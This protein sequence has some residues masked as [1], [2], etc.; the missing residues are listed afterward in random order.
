MTLHHAP[1]TPWRPKKNLDAGDN[2]KVGKKKRRAAPAG[3]AGDD[4]S[5]RRVLNLRPDRKL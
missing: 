2:A 4:L 1:A 5:V 3:A